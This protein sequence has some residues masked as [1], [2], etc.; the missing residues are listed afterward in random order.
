MPALPRTRTLRRQLATQL[1]QRLNSYTGGH[2]GRM[3]DDTS[4]TTLEAVH[5]AACLALLDGHSPEAVR[6][7]TDRAI[8][9]Y[10]RPD[11]PT[12]ERVNQ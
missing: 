2:G 6:A 9:L 3:T 1:R 12:V 10:E 4:R 5:E 11:P 8:T 7:A